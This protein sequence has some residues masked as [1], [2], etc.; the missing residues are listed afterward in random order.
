MKKCS[1]FLSAFM[2]FFSAAIAQTDTIYTINNDETIGLGISQIT[3][4]NPITGS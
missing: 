2:F 3:G 1:A 4:V